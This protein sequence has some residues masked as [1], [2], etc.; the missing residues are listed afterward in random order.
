MFLIVG[1]GCSQASYLETHS[2][3]E[4]IFQKK[5]YGGAAE[6]V[7]TE[8]NAPSF[9]LYANGRVIYYRYIDGKRKMAVAVLTREE[10]LEL[11]K[12]I[13]DLLTPVDSVFLDGSGDAPITEYYFYGRRIPIKGLHQSESAFGRFNESIDQMYFKKSMDYIPE[14]I[15]LY[16]KRLSS[17]DASAWPEWNI[18]GIDLEKIYMK[19]ISFYEPNSEE[20]SIIIEG[21]LVNRV[22]NF[23]EQTGVYKKCVFN[24]HVFAVGYRPVLPDKNFNK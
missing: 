2:P 22:Q 15:V 10:F 19:D 16:V 13:S 17:G 20:N 23:I 21:K 3:W 14:K 24:K 6:L 18:N 9:S 11:L 4:M 12:V 8:L 1:I 5:V 7:G